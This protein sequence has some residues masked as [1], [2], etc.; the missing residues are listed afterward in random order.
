M[1]RNKYITDRQA[2]MVKEAY[3]GTIFHVTSGVSGILLMRRISPK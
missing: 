1:E 2:E 3:H